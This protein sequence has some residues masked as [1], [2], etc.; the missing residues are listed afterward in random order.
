MNKSL[1]PLSCPELPYPH[2]PKVH[3]E[4]GVV[5]NVLTFHLWKNSMVF[6]AV[7]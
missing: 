2:N 5:D 1:G 7:E 4:K 3:C 6:D